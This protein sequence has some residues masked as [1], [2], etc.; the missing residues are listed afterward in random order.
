MEVKDFMRIRVPISCS[1]R[2]TQLDCFAFKL[3]QRYLSHMFIF[4]I[5]SSIILSMF[6]CRNCFVSFHFS[7][8]FLNFQTCPQRLSVGSEWESSSK[9]TGGVCVCVFSYSET[10]PCRL[11][12]PECFRF[13][14]RPVATLPGHRVFASQD[15]S[16]FRIE[17]VRLENFLCLSSHLFIYL[18]I[19][20]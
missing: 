10:R 17:M 5:L 20:L 12:F 3:M 8:H 2:G 15:E 1:S 19:Y 4:Y 7:R 14:K 6:L 13:L 16:I 11:L 18:F 9:K